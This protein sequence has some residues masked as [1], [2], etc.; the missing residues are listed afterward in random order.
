MDA[1]KYCHEYH[2]HTVLC[3]AMI[4]YLQSGGTIDLIVKEPSA[5]AVID[6]FD[7]ETKDD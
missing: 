5:S 1:C 2:L 6:G 4:E 3:D 7:E